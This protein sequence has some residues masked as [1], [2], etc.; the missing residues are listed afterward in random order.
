MVHCC[1]ITEVLRLYNGKGDAIAGRQPQVHAARP[2]HENADRDLV[3]QEIR[4]GVYRANESLAPGIW[5]LAVRVESHQGL[6][7]AERFRLTIR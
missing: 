1:L 6:D 4:P 7:Y 5:L 3:L 2:T